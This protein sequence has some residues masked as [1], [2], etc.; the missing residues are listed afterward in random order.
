MMYHLPVTIASQP[1]AGQQSK[2]A[3]GWVGLLRSNDFASAEAAFRATIAKKPNDVWALNGLVGTLLSLDRHA[4][5][6]EVAAKVPSLVQAGSAEQCY[7]LHSWGLALRKAGESA[8]AQAKAEDL[9]RIFPIYAPG[10]YQLGL[11]Q[12]DQ[13]NFEEAANSFR[14]ALKIDPNDV[15]SADLLVD[16]LNSLKQPKEELEAL[17]RL[18]ELQKAANLPH[19]ARTLR[20]W[21]IVLREEGDVDQAL[22]K[23]QELV[24]TFPDYAPGWN[25]RAFT[26]QA[27]GDLDGA[28]A[29]YGKA[30]EVGRDAAERGTWMFNLG[31]VL[32][33]KGSLEEAETVYRDLVALDPGNAGAENALGLTLAEMKQYDEATACYR[34]AFALWDQVGSPNRKFAL[35]NW[36]DVY[37]DRKEPKLAEVKLREALAADDSDPDTHNSLG[38]ALAQN[39]PDAAI[40]A[41]QQALRLWAA[42]NS[43]NR[44]FALRN[45]AIILTERKQLA[46]AEAKLREALEAD[47]ND[48]DVR[49]SLGLALA[50]HAPDA[51]IEQY[52][53]AYA[54]W[55]GSPNQ[56]TA[57]RLWANDLN[58]L[59][60]YETAEAK[61]REALDVSG[62][63]DAPSIHLELGRAQLG[64]GHEERALA[65][66]IKARESAPEDDGDRRFILWELGNVLLKRERLDEALAAYRDAV[67]LS[68][69]G[70]F[71]GPSSMVS[72][73]PRPAMRRRRSRSMR[74]RSGG[75]KHIPTPI[76]TRRRSCSDSGSTR[77][78]G[79][80]GRPPAPGISR[81]K[82]CL[83]VMR[84]NAARSARV[85]AW[86][87]P[88]TMPM[89]CATYS[90]NM[91]I[92]WSCMSSY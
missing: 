41:Y 7:N 50:Q 81:S 24:D 53:V 59:R 86:S 27:K 26:L 22:V 56:R 15:G 73:L 44:K 48:P 6:T 35:R 52:K 18:N 79:R 43:P 9:T 63:L 88:S 4:E 76:T 10:W 30:L 34:R 92:R 64:E 89:R 80:H 47:P 49:N 77:R 70:E 32:R 8:D 85:S 37:L 31:D 69:A 62:D 65:E 60:D 19:R 55:K 84:S 66:L 87:A 67:A 38:N 42:T 13:K 25:T 46:Q 58:I 74:K 33:K 14:S 82:R 57:L 68:P 36:A 75:T 61:C 54:A 16:T 71:W 78:D 2:H 5:A 91:S 21:A 17:S 72:L 51:A 12:R 40:Q 39:D 11:I 29:N 3:C 1:H 20:N 45:W 28:I 83:R 90:A 23:A